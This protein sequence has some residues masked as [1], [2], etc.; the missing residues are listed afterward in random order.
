MDTNLLTPTFEMLSKT[1][2]PDFCGHKYGWFLPP[3][4][5]AIKGKNKKQTQTQEALANCPECNPATH[6]QPQF[7]K[8][9]HLSF[10]KWIRLS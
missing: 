1:L 6:L 10:Q 3:R 2:S 8:Q 5:L 4:W 9:I 7:E